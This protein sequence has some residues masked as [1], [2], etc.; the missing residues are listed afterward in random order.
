MNFVDLVLRTYEYSYPV[1]D[2]LAW[3]HVDLPSNLNGTEGG[4]EHSYLV[5]TSTLIGVACKNNWG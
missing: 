1:F 4:M 3:V 5:S 2:M